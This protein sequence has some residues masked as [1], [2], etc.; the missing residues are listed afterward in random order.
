[1]PLFGWMKWSHEAEEQM[2]DEVPRPETP[3]PVAGHVLLS[4]LLWHAEERERLTRQLEQ[5]HRLACSSLGTRLFPKYPMLRTPIPVSDLLR[6][7][8]LCAQVPP[9]HAAA[10]LS[11]FREILATDN[12]IL[13]WELVYVFKQVLRDFLSKE[14]LEEHP[15]P[16]A[17]LR[18]VE[19]WTNRYQ[20]KHGCIPPTAPTRIGDPRREEI[21]TIS[22]DVD[23]AMRRRDSLAAY[24]GWDLP[25][26]CPVPVK[27]TEAY[28]TTL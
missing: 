21:P 3:G 11:R 28:S 24:R 22:G 16:Q 2:K 7:E 27:A 20:M 6:L 1:M 19:A 17:K 10:V 26:H 9:V 15:G 8:C 25:Y 18:P 23:R 5:E 4:Q 12:I 14:E 13:P